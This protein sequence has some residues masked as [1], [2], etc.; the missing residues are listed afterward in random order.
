[1]N[2]IAIFDF[3]F[4][5]KLTASA[6]WCFIGGTLFQQLGE[7]DTMKVFFLV[8]ILMFL[9]IIIFVYLDYMNYKHYLN[10]KK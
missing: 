2:T 4:Y 1:M 9:I 6:M 8:G 7:Q 5:W 3:K 10:W